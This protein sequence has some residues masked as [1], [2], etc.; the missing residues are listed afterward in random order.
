MAV[1]DSGGHGDGMAVVETGLH[2]DG[3]AVVEKV[4]GM[5]ITTRVVEGIRMVW[6]W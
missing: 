6:Q 4:E 2:G 1:V 3:V 5:G